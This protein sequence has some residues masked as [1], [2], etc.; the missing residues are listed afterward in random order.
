MLA[1]FIVFMSFG[2]LAM[3][4]GTGESSNCSLSREKAKKLKS[5][6]QSNSLYQSISDAE[7]YLALENKVGIGNLEFKAEDMLVVF[8]NDS[9]GSQCRVEFKHSIKGNPDSEI[10]KDC[11]V[12]YELQD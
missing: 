3:A 12:C 1:L 5:T 6:K 4:H 11:T 9:S 10:K 2:T 7:T 8:V